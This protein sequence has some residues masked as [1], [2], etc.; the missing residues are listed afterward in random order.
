[1]DEVKYFTV[2]LEPSS[3]QLFV[4][5]YLRHIPTRTSG[6]HSWFTAWWTCSFSDFEARNAQ[7]SSSE[8]AR[9]L[10]WLRQIN[11]ITDSLRFDWSACYAP[12]RKA[13]YACLIRSTLMGT[14]WCDQNSRFACFHILTLSGKYWCLLAEEKLEIATD[15]SFL[16]DVSLKTV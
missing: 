8:S 3:H 14:F 10:C 9:T 6:S 4:V 13:R 15:P 2:I 1:M 16:I 11:R 12:V 5:L 7:W